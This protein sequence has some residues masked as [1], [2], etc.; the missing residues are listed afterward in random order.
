[1]NGE[2]GHA[3]PLQEAARPMKPNLGLQA[4][5][6]LPGSLQ[7]TQ[8][9]ERAE[10]EGGLVWKQHLQEQNGRCLV[11]QV[12][13]TCIGINRF[14]AIQSNLIRSGQRTMSVLLNAAYHKT[15]HV[16]HG[17]LDT[18]RLPLWSVHCAVHGS[19]LPSRVCCACQTSLGSSFSAHCGHRQMA[20]DTS[21]GQVMSNFLLH[22]HQGAEIGGCKQMVT[23]ALQL[24]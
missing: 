12:C 7:C 20:K 17:W 3:R 13:C 5:Q 2:T 4:A 21:L 19:C 23:A 10:G 24:P 8:H 22:N 11:R 9:G 1:M 16:E 14:N 15:T 18:V 6:G